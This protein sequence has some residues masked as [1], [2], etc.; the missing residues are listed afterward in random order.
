MMGCNINIITVLS[1]VK[2]ILVVSILLVINKSR[3]RSLKVSY[4][5]VGDENK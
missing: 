4:N 3:R 2:D 1:V 5:R